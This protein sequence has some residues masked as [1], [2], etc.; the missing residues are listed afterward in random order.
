MLIAA[1]YSLSAHERGQLGLV[2]YL[3][4]S[5]DV[6]GSRLKA[7]GRG[8]CPTAHLVSHYDYCRY[9]SP[10]VLT[11]ALAPPPPPLPSP[12]PK[13][14]PHLPVP[15]FTPLLFEAPPPLARACLPQRSRQS[16]GA[17][18]VNDTALT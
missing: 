12:P 7:K 4:G 2:D 6:W 8:C 16:C 1:P 13:P 14:P 9:P 11:A 5:G 3:V 10:L 15:R 17:Q 18:N